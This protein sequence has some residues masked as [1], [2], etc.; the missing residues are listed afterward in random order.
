MSRAS[1]ASPPLAPVSA[2]QRAR[3][4]GPMFRAIGTS[5]PE[6]SEPQAQVVRRMAELW[7]LKGT[8]L[9]RWERIAAGAGIETRYGVRPMEEVI[10]LSTAKRMTIYEE[11]APEL[12]AAAAMQALQ[13]ADITPNDVTDLIVV[14]CTGFSA[15]GVDIALVQRLGLPASVRRTM[16]GFMGCFGAISGLRTAVGACSA[17]P[18]AIALVVCVE[19]CSLHLRADDDV[20]NQ[21]ASALFGDGAAAALVVGPQAA[22]P[23]NAGRNVGSAQSSAIGELAVGNSLLLPHGREWMTW[24]VTDAGFAMT[25]AREVPEALRESLG[26][27]VGRVCPTRPRSF[28]VHPGGPGILDAVQHA[29]RLNDHDLRASRT[30]LRRCGNMSSATVLFVLEE[31]MRCGLELPAMLLSFGPGLTIESTQILSG[32]D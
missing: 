21:V 25:L 31:A 15:P 16:I 2:P 27:F 19:L 10:H 3:A 4:A 17:N 9:T 14:S 6:T 1:V 24:R 11:H 22:P 13:Q 23:S 29:L 26:E 28:I 7:K 20:Q 5:L 8:A 18:E 32:T 12:A 30:V